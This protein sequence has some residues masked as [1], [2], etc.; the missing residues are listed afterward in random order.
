MVAPLVQR[1][2]RMSIARWGLRARLR[3]M[4]FRRASD[5]SNPP[6]PF[7]LTTSGSFPGPTLATVGGV[8]VSA[9]GDWCLSRPNA[10]PTLAGSWPLCVANRVVPGLDV[11]L[12]E[13]G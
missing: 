3:G 5:S 7:H 9:I 13:D 1:V 11:K 8:I 12:R 4:A 2:R 6:H 10:V